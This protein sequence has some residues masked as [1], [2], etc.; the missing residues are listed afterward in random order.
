[1]ENP[2]VSE[3]CLELTSHHVINGLSVHA[4]LTDYKQSFNPHLTLNRSKTH[5][6]WINN[7]S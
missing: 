3:C 6:E 5:S 4:G 7:S 2:L 1:M